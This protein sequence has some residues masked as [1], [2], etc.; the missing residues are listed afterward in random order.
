[1]V[2]NKIGAGSLR[3][4]SAMFRGGEW[5]IDR[6]RLEWNYSLRKDRLSYAD[7]MRTRE[8]NKG[9]LRDKEMLTLVVSSYCLD[10]FDETDLASLYCTTVI[11]VLVLTPRTVHF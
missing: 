8:R 11:P 6:G 7:M 5:S 1:M 10:R 3:K 2:L 4:G 9:V